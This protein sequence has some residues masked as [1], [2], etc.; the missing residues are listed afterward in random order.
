[1]ANETK[2]SLVEE[3]LLQMKALEE[4]VTENAKGILASTM[5]EEISEL[6]KESLSGTKKPKSR[7]S[8]QEDEDIED[9]EDVEDIEDVEYENEP[10]GDD[11]EE[12]IDFEMSDDEGDDQEFDMTMM[13]FDDMEDENEMAPL[14]MRG[15]SPEEL[16][17]VFKAMGE[18]DGIIISKD[19]DYIHLSDDNEDVEYLIQNES[20][21]S[22]EDETMEAYEEDE[23]VVYE[24]EMDEEEE[25]EN[26]TIYELEMDEEEDEEE[27]DEE[28][29]EDLD[30]VY[31]SM[32]PKGK[33]GKMKQFKYPNMKHGVTETSDEENE[34][35]WKEE[36]EEASNLFLKKP[37]MRKEVEAKES[38][39]TLG[40]GKSHGRNGLPKPRTYSSHVKL[41]SYNKEIEVLREKNEEYKKALDFFRTKLNEVAVFN[42]NLAYATRL[43]TEH[44]T[45]KQ[46]KINILR[47]FDNVES[48]KESK[49]LYKSIK[50]ELDGITNVVT[51]SVASKVIKTPTTGSSNLIESKTYEN[52]QFLRMKDLMNKIK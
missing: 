24:L 23:E 34:S 39:R 7:I 8:E 29:E 37:K 25:E 31:E 21:N 42:S 50:E 47:R 10:T 15:A 12:D 5:K 1:M 52:P 46:E 11:E 40:V 16:A 27:S 41:E 4:A 2:N 9:V 14:D 22:Y 19:D 38:S 49:G 51:E 17:K 44:T 45:T 20:D 30:E 28:E 33:V 18:D 6:V 32:K 13:G 3:A 48:I 36:M 43:F 35:E 26:E